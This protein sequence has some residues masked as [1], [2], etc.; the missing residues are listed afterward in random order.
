MILITGSSGKLGS[1]LKIIFPDA[2]TP[3]HEELNISRR[4]DVF[5]YIEKNKPDVIIHTAALT[6][7]GHCENNK[8]TA[9]ETNVG[10][11]ENLVD[12]CLEYKPNTFFMY[13]STACVFYG[14]SEMYNENDIPNPKN[15]YAMTKLIG[16]FISKKLEK[17]LIIRTN[18]VAKE[19][20]MYPKAFTDRFGTYL[21][22]EDVARGIKDVMESEMKGIVHIVGNKK[23]SMFELAKMTTENVQPMTLNEYSGP[24]VTVNMTLDTSKW[25]KYK[26]SS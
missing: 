11:T 23:I 24:A 14:D 18:F 15:F 12:A 25:K 13:V 3:S 2:L 16:E 8:K 5:E 6:G 10:G 4:R 7:V 20:W 9:W 1:Q 21:F 17:H 26:I 19:K 22:A